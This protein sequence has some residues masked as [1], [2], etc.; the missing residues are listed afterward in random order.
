MESNKTRTIV[1]ITL[2]A[3]VSSQLLAIGHDAPSSTLAIQFADKDGQTSVYQYANFPAEKFAEFQAAESKG[4]FF[5]HQVK[6][7]FVEQEG[8]QEKVLAYPYERLT[9]EEVAAFITLP[10]TGAAATETA[11]AETRQEEA[12]AA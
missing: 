4:S 12:V 5:I 10:Q 9:S 11:A 7:A 3:V 6:N 8:T 1:A 2:A